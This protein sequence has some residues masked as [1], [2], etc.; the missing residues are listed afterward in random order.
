[1]NS[2]VGLKEITRRGR[3]ISFTIKT[4]STPNNQKIALLAETAIFKRDLY[5]LSL[6]DDAR[7][8]RTSQDEET[9][10]TTTP[11]AF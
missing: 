11:G 10:G 8:A 6:E 3:R 7:F 5:P 9:A 1:M 2:Y 4:M